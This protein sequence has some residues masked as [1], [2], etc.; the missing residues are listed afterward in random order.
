MIGAV[1]FKT[2]NPLYDPTIYLTA[3]P[4][5]LTPENLGSSQWCRD[6]D[7]VNIYA[8]ADPLQIYIH[9]HFDK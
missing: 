9:A 8:V 5:I 4:L 7:S 2:P 1:L 6:Q 3:A